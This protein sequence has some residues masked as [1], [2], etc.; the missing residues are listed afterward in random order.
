MKENIFNYINYFKNL[1]NDINY[2]KILNLRNITKITTYINLR[3]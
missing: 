3:S 2:F 1:K